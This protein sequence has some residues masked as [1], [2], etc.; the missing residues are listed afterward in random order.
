MKIGSDPEVFVT[1]N[2]QIIPV[3]GLIGGDK[4]K[5][6]ELQEGGV[7]EDNVLAE[8]N[9]TPC[10]TSTEFI[11]RHEMVMEQV[12][13]KYNLGFSKRASYTFPEYSLDQYPQALEFGCGS[14]LNA[15]SGSI[16]P[17]PSPDNN[18]FRTAGGHI[19]IGWSDEGTVTQMQQRK[20]GVLCDYF[21]GLPSVLKD[22]DTDR[23]SLYGKAGCIRYK[24]YGIE[25]RTLS[26]FWLF[27]MLDM[28]WAFNQ[29]TK[30]YRSL[31]N[32]DN[33][34]NHINPDLVQQAINTSDVGLATDLLRQLE[35]VA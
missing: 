16:N 9:I 13:Q 28:D 20:V 15:L 8:F 17:K 11:T 26:N 32:F 3:C 29:A 21:L 24:P 31:D 14:D 23:R 5:P 12:R 7:L 33:I 35:E 34:I 22:N 4:G 30:A 6:V 27:N 1:R 18:G 25:Y 19:H 2:N 10:T